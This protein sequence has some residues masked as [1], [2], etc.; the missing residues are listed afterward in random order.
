[1]ERGPLPNLDESVL[2]V[3]Q[4]LEMER[5][6]KKTGIIVRSVTPSE[7][8]E[9]YHIRSVPWL[10]F[11]GPNGII[12]Y[13]GGYS[14][15]R[16]PRSGYLDIQLWNALRTG[17]NPVPLPAYGCAIAQQLQRRLDPLG[18]KYGS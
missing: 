9:Q 16:Y 5:D 18:L 14:P 17:A 15:E 7:A 1:M 3:G 2:L 8:A 10:V 11:V 12:R 6:L 13:A 4:D